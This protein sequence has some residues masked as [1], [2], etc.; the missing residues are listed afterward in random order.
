LN[1]IQQKVIKII[2]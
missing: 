2:K 1:K